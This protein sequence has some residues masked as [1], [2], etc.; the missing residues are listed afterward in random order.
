MTEKGIWYVIPPDIHIIP[1]TGSIHQ[2]VIAIA[3][4]NEVRSQDSALN[5]GVQSGQPACHSS[6]DIHNA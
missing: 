5:K 6:A 2:L 3:P 4:R 1:S